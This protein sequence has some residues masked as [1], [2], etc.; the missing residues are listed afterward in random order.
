[1]EHE[2][3]NKSKS[4]ALAQGA[5]LVGIVKVSDLP[6]HAENITKILPSA[7]YVIVVADQTTIKQPNLTR[8]TPTGSVNNLSIKQPV[9]LC[10]KG[11]SRLRCLPSFP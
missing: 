6:E 8:Y 9:T 4:V 1:M 3:S 11:F 10:Q 2:L 7:R 5:D